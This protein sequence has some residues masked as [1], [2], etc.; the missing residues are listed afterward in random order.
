MNIRKGDTVKILAGRER[1]KTGKV[2]TV[3][4]KSGRAVV[5]GRNI[6]IRHERPRRSG[7]KGQKVQF[8]SPLHVSK[9]MVL[10]PHCGKATR[11][12]HM[13]DDKNLKTRICKH[14]GKRI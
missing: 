8:P 5:E 9:L 12:A 3:N 2:L 4:S 11:G 1:G 10:C 7:E 13:I 6:T 14:C